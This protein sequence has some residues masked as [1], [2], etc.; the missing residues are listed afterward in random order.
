MTNTPTP[1]PSQLPPPD[2]TTPTYTAFLNATMSNTS[3]QKASPT[4]TPNQA[5]TSQHSSG[6]NSTS[7]KYCHVPLPE[8]IPLLVT[9]KR[10]EA[11]NLTY[12]PG[13]ATP[14]G[15]KASRKRSKPDSKEKFKRQ[16]E[17]V[18]GELRHQIKRSRSDIP[19][20]T[21]ISSGSAGLATEQACPP[22]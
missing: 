10:L 15:S 16:T 14:T 7:S 9:S 18:N 5:I 3:V 2:T 17:M 19:Q 12:Q 21:E 4:S 1:H 11:M 8:N 20:A 22:P 13:I 6:S